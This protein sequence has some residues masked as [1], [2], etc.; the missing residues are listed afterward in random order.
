MF[1][2]FIL[3]PASGRRYGRKRMIQEHASDASNELPESSQSS[4]PETPAIKTE[5]EEQE[6]EWL[7][8]RSVA[9]TF[10]TSGWMRFV[11]AVVPVQVKVEEM[12][13]PIESPHKT[14]QASLRPVKQEKTEQQTESM[15]PGREEVGSP[16]SNFRETTVQSENKNT[17]QE[18][19]KAGSRGN[20]SSQDEMWESNTDQDQAGETEDIDVWEGEAFTDNKN[21]PSG[22][23]NIS[24]DKYVNVNRIV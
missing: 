1:L 22:G 23:Q 7:A 12:E 16:K 21:L 13:T 24:F 11:S 19:L 9:S 14:Q 3:F 17:D 2:Y 18:G 4:Q 20:D 6:S 15:P 5:A 10:Q 8:L